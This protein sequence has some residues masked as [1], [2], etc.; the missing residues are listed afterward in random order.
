MLTL[1]VN[2][3]HIVPE[4]DFFVC[5]GSMRDLENAFDKVKK[6]HGEKG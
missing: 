3:P 5:C 4:A 6:A 2:V 1:F